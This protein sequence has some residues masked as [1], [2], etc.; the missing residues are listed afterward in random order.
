MSARRLLGT[1]VLLGVVGVATGDTSGR[2]GPPPIGRWDLTVRG[3]DGEYPSWLEVR[4]SGYTTLVGT[5]VGR[6]GSARPVGRVEF[7]DGKLR[8][9][10]PPQWE[11]RPDDLTFEGRLKGEEFRGETTDEQGRR[12]T[13]VGRRAPA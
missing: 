8:F 11:K 4:K 1:L 6:F 10:V 5:F 2:V 9:S 12:V 13:G 3:P 7:A